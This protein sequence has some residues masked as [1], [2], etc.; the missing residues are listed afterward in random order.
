MG[1]R[2]NGRVY[3]ILAKKKGEKIR[4]IEKLFIIIWIKCVTS[5]IIK[6]KIPINGKPKYR[7]LSHRKQKTN[8]QF[9]YMYDLLAKCCS[10]FG[11]LVFICSINFISFK[12]YWFFQQ[13][14]KKNNQNKLNR[15]NWNC[16]IEKNDKKNPDWTRRKLR[17][18]SCRLI[19]AASLSMY[20]N[21][22]IIMGM[23]FLGVDRRQAGTLTQFYL[24][25]IWMTVVV[26][27]VGGWIQ[28]GIGFWM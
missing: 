28:S 21:M 7:I 5:I 10:F 24:T 27:I 25:Q 14:Q 4:K 13:Q 12:F 19:V 23:E 2:F 1:K 22:R 15:I 8:S 18:I 20:Y 11:R 26:V 17:K 3:I 16:L 6:I 9:I